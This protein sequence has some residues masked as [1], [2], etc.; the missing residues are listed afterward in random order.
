MP[1]RH[2]FNTVNRKKRCASHLRA[3]WYGGDMTEKEVY[4]FIEKMKKYGDVW[5]YED[6]VKAYGNTELEEALE[7]R[8]FDISEFSSLTGMVI[9]EEDM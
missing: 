7:D 6:V 4:L 5:E 3:L 9:D 2:P 1:C 8:K